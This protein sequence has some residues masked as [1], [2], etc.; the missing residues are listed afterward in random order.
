M[1]TPPLR[2]TSPMRRILLNSTAN[3]HDPF[4]H[5]R[6]EASG[7]S[8]SV[9]AGPNVFDHP[10]YD[11]PSVDDDGDSVRRISHFPRKG[12]IGARFR[13]GPFQFYGCLPFKANPIANADQNGDGVK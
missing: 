11:R 3:R 2:T 7:D 6:V 10:A 1:K 9:L 4:D 12:T 8:R 5:C 13:C